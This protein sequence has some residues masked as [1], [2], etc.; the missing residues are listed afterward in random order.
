MALPL[1]YS[2]RNL[3]HRR[4]AVGLTVLCIAAIIA[5]FAG[6]LAFADGVQRAL[7]VA[8]QPDVVVAL[9]QGA[10]AETNS[11]ITPDEFNLLTALTQLRRDGNEVYASPEIMV[12]TSLSRRGGAED[13]LANVA[14]RG[15]DPIALKVHPQVKIVEGRTFNTGNYEVI[16]GKAAAERFNGLAVGAQIPLGFQQNDLFTIVGIFEAAGGPFESEIWGYRS[17]IANVHRRT[18]PSSVYLRV[19]DPAQKQQVIDTVQGP[20]IRLTAKDE[21]QY[22]ADLNINGKWLIA[23]TFSLIL[24][25]GTGAAFA[26]ANTMYAMIA[27]RTREVAML[28]AIGFRPRSILFALLTEAL[29]LALFAGLL[30]TAAALTL[31]G[32]SQ[33]MMSAGFTTVAFKF[34]VSPQTIAVSILAAAA[35]GVLG[36]LFPAL[37]AARLR[38]TTA[39]REG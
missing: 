21:Q 7:T 37:R 12:Q 36:A 2:I 26:V 34:Y 16:V 30:G 11:M 33:D 19:A 10:T 39:L 24:F 20:T 3:L 13:V 25:M 8:A 27:H 18:A 9:K 22:Y 38:I 15:V 17:N 35:I 28:R 1:N 23:I 29:L 32:R 31:S 6:L 4:L 5:V 14:V